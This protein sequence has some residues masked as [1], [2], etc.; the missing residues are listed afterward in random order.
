MLGWCM[1]CDGLGFDICACHSFFYLC[2][3]FNAFVMDGRMDGWMSIWMG[4]NMDG[5]KRAGDGGT[6]LFPFLM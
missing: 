1:V 6:I 4:E 5:S 3:L 2:H